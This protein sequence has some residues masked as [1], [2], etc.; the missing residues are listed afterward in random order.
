[1]PQSTTQ[2]L[3]R[4]IQI[5]FAF[6][7]DR[8]LLTI[9][10][11]SAVTGIPKSSCYRL[12]KT[13]R[14]HDLIQLDR[15]LKGCRLG[16]GLLTLH[17]IILDSLDISRIALPY[18]EKLSQHSGETAQLVLR[19]NDVGVCIEKVE[20]SKALVVRPDKGTVVLLHTGASGK[21]ILAY[22]DPHEQ[23]RVIREKGLPPKGPGT[24][25]DPDVLRANLKQIRRQGYAISDQEIY[26]GVKAVAAPIFGTDG[27]VAASVC[28]A[29][30]KERFDE[31]EIGSLVDLI[32]AAARAITAKLGGHADGEN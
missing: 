26:S 18:L 22:L 6:S 19:N 9:D 24:I 11:I 17:S 16:L 4:A 5:L 21:V 20:S 3:E 30:P 8:P 10:Q 14:Q 29:G 12:I 32:K 7:H 28:I 15:S 31:Q 23:E 27:K 2:S 13:L 1:M 25:T